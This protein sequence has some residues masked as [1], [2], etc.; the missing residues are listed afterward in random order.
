MDEIYVQVKDVPPEIIAAAKVLYNWTEMHNVEAF[1]GFVNRSKYE[2]LSEL[3]H[4]LILNVSSCFDNE[5]RHQTA[6]RYIKQMENLAYDCKE[7]QD[8][9]V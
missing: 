1:G 6:L 8:K 5:T 3:Y 9:A 4:E 2:D 7:Y